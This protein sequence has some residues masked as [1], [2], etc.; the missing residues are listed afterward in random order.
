MLVLLL[1]STDPKTSTLLLIRALNLKGAYAR[2]YIDQPVYKLRAL[3]KAYDVMET[4]CCH[5]GIP[6]P[7]VFRHLDCTDIT[8][9]E[10]SMYAFLRLYRLVCRV[11]HVD[12]SIIDS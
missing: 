2:V 4:S 11:F 6:R 5:R 7:D 12:L 9:G 3:R 10:L 1:S 8:V